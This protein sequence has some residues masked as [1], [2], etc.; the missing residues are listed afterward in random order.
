[1]Q[2]QAWLLKQEITKGNSYYKFL[3]VITNSHITN[4]CFNILLIDNMFRAYLLKGK[5]PIINS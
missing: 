5:L 2:V 3:E 1:M 4:T